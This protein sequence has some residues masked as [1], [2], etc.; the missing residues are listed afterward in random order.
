MNKAVAKKQTTDVVVG[1]SLDGWG[2]VQDIDQSNVIIP[3]ILPM[4]S[5]SMLVVE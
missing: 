2:N 3:K 1:D 4:Q 5:T